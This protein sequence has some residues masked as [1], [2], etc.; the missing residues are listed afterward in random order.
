MTPATEES[1]PGLQSELKP[2]MDSLINAPATAQ[3]L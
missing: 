2:D 1:I 3:S